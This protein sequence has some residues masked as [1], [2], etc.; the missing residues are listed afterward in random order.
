[1]NTIVLNSKNIETLKA[2]NSPDKVTEVKL[3]CHIHLVSRLRMNT[4]VHMAWTRTNCL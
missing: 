2:I 4:A 1:M 3:T